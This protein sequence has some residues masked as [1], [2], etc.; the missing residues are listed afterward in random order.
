M[1]RRNHQARTADGRFAPSAGDLFKLPKRVEPAVATRL[2]KQMLEQGTRGLYRTN[3]KT[4]LAL[5]QAK[6]A[7]LDELGAEPPPSAVVMCETLARTKLLLDALDGLLLSYGDRIINRRRKEAYPLLRQREEL[8]R[9][10]TQQLATFDQLKATTAIEQR[11]EALEHAQT[12][13]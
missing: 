7:L 9:H 4:T 6:N 13:R 3:R 5:N 1:T 8:A 2:K 10:L 11:L 12:P